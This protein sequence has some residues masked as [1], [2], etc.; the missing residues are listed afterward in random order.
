MPAC[1]LMLA[2]MVGVTAVSV[3]TLCWQA[4]M[5]S[6]K[7]I[8]RVNNRFGMAVFGDWALEIGDWEMAE[9]NNL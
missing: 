6:R 2:K 7:S 9:H 3:G 8:V 1:L 5:V 4:V